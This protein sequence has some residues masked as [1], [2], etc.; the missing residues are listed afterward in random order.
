MLRVTN[1]KKGDVNI[2][3]NEKIEAAFGTLKVM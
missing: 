3:E 1:D 2:V